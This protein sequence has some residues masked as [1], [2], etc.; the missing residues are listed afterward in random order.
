[1]PLERGWK[2]GSRAGYHVATTW[3]ILAE[4]VQRVARVDFA[5]YVRERVFEPLG[6]TVCGWECPSRDLRRMGIGLHCCRR[7][8]R[9]E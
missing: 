6:M 7:C 5:E 9:R 4:I 1:M 2:P 3:F 8:R